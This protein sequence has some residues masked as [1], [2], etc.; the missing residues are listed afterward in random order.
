M[1]SHIFAENIF[2]SRSFPSFEIP[3]MSGFRTNT[4]SSPIIN[5]ELLESSLHPAPI[6]LWLD[7]RYKEKKK[8]DKGNDGRGN[9]GNSKTIDFTIFCFTLYYYSAFPSH[10]LSRKYRYFDT[11]SEF[12]RGFLLSVQSVLVPT[13]STSC[14]LIRHYAPIL[15][16][17]HLMDRNLTQLIHLLQTNIDNNKT[18]N[19]NS[20]SNNILSPQYSIIER[21][22]QTDGE[23]I[24]IRLSTLIDNTSVSIPQ[25]LLNF[26]NTKGN[27]ASIRLSRLSNRIKERNVAN[28]SNKKHAADD[29]ITSVPIL[30][31]LFKRFVD[32]CNRKKISSKTG[33][34]MYTRVSSKRISNDDSVFSN[35]GVIR[36][37]R[38][39]NS[40]N[41]NNN[42]T[43]IL[44]LQ[45]LLNHARDD[46]NKNNSTSVAL[47]LLSKLL[48]CNSNV[49][50]T[51]IFIL[52]VL[53]DGINGDKE[54]KH[55]SKLS[56]TVL[57]IHV[58][59][60][61]ND[62]NNILILVSKLSNH[63]DRDDNN[64]TD[65]INDDLLL[66]KERNKIETWH[67]IDNDEEGQ[68]IVFVS[69]ID[70]ESVI[71][72]LSK[73]SKHTSSNNG[74]DQS[75]DEII[76]SIL[77]K[78]LNHNNNGDVHSNCKDNCIMILI[79]KYTNTIGNNGDNRTDDEIIS[80]LFLNLSKHNRDENNTEYIINRDNN[81]DN[82]L[83][84]LSKLSINNCTARNEIDCNNCNVLILY[85]ECFLLHDRSIIDTSLLILL[86]KLLN[87]TNDDIRGFALIPLSNYTY[88]ARKASIQLLS[89]RIDRNKKKINTSI[90]GTSVF[91]SLSK[92]TNIIN[93]ND[94]NRAIQAIRNNNNCDRTVRSTLIV[95]EAERSSKT[96]ESSLIDNDDNNDTEKCIDYV[97]I[98]SPK[99][100]KCNDE[101]SYNDNINDEASAFIL[102]LK[103][104][105]EER[106]R[107]EEDSNRNS[108][109]NYVSHINNN[110][111]P[112]VNNIF[113]NIGSS[114]IIDQKVVTTRSTSTTTTDNSM[115]CKMN[116]HITT[117]ALTTYSDNLIRHGS[118]SNNDNSI[119]VSQLCLFMGSVCTLLFLVL[120]AMR[121]FTTLA[122][123][124]QEYAYD[125]IL[126][127]LFVFNCSIL[128]W[129]FTIDG[130]YQNPQRV[131]ILVNDISLYESS[132]N[133]A[134]RLEL[135][136]SSSKQINAAK[137]SQILHVM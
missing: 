59:I 35:D 57:S 101:K 81:N 44:I 91:I 120:I 125:I 64:S 116:N 73:L 74:D 104:R 88:T 85:C 17:R 30:K 82:M 11:Q 132:W 103:Q 122:T 2:M 78:L 13:S 15:K 56:I 69:L 54:P 39:K 83:I 10:K 33:E 23:C 34:C 94:H 3:K 20:N 135:Y 79:P 53:S 4:D 105:K 110:N 96:G 90:I 52:Q 131:R 117:T 27:L 41:Y 29:Y 21:V 50:D 24:V 72:I 109:E 51:N 49:D 113:N 28:S 22:I 14:I 16:L 38:D 95:N 87:H 1:M 61:P 93:Y 99:L 63:T 111:T 118:N 48:N 129:I 133:R 62:T 32:R 100:S 5:G 58:T 80:I 31:V 92:R 123:C 89:N 134:L 76:L 107:E 119:G 19:N 98:L 9:D 25:D 68:P 128:Y 12:Y 102:I 66:Q 18:C 6:S 40:T 106:K 84:L 45:V 86:L 70:G 42:K 47:L 77:S 26:I 36:R 97:L 115:N 108:V 136:L 7:F 121:Y 43:S 65:Y 46:E 67:I 130:E 124:I 137:M 114:I 112:K 8:S 127:A 55:R 37:E 75:D 71:I 60:C 126:K